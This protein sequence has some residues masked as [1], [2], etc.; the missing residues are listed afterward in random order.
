[1][2]PT[3]D[4]SAQNFLDNMRNRTHSYNTG[5]K[6]GSVQRHTHRGAEAPADLFLCLGDGGAACLEGI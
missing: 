3:L 1:M 6:Q 5:R 4:N 2:S